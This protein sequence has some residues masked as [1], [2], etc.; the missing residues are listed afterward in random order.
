MTKKVAPKPCFLSNGAATVRCDL[1]ESS[2]VKTTSLSG[3]GSRAR[4]CVA[5]TRRSSKVGRRMGLV[6]LEVCVQSAKWSFGTSSDQTSLL[7]G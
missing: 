3:I 4:A 1:L 5:G 6:P 2:N 7:S